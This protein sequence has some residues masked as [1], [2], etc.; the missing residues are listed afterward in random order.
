MAGVSRPGET[1]HDAAEQRQ[2]AV[3]RRQQSPHEAGFEGPS[4]DQ[5]LDPAVGHDNTCWLVP[6]P[7]GYLLRNAS[8]SEEG[9]CIYVVAGVGLEPTTS[10][11]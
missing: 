5:L 8:P 6:Q 2:D 4:G 1:N 7:L 3:V 10:G 9:A 11:L